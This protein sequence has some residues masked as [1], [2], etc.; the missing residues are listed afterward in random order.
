[1]AVIYMGQ[2]RAGMSFHFKII[3]RSGVVYQ[4]ANSDFLAMILSAKEQKLLWQRELPHSRVRVQLFYPNKRRVGRE[5]VD[6]AL[7]ALSD[8]AVRSDVEKRIAAASAKNAA[9]A[10]V[11]AR[12]EAR[13]ERTAAAVFFAGREATIFSQAGVVAPPDS[14]TGETFRVS[15]LARF[16]S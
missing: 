7:R 11:L 2:P 4:A 12:S 3:C 1:M 13:T 8:T 5:A 14:L 9:A 6:V 16:D 15:N 10:G